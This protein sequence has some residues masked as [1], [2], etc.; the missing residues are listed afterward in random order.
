MQQIHA[1][2]NATIPRA[3]RRGEKSSTMDTGPYGSVRERLEQRQ[4]ANMLHAFRP[5]GGFSSGQE[6]VRHLSPIW[7]DP[8]SALAN[9]IMSRSILVVTWSDQTLVPMFQFDRGGMSL[10]PT[11]AQVAAELKPVFDDWELVH[12]FATPNTW[13]DDTKPVERL[14]SDQFG[15]LQAARTDRFIARG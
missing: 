8:W 2:S 1:N 7:D 11:C 6:M 15:V 13:L 4:F 14:A 12:W 9:W 3:F 10:D 5:Y